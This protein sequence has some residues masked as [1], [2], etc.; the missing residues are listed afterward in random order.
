MAPNNIMQR[1][2]RLENRHTGEK[3]HI[4]RVR[5]KDGG[6]ILLLDGSLP[7]GS[8]GP[9]MH[10]HLTQLEEGTI[11]SGT[12]GAEVGGKRIRLEAG[13]GGVFPA[14]VAHTWWNDG[15]TLLEF[16]G[17]V[18]PAADL[19]RFLQAVFAVVNAGPKDR[20]PLFYLAHVLWRHRETQFI[21]APPRLVQSVMFPLVIAIGRLLGKY[22]GD[23]WPGSPASCPGAPLD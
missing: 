12:L 13:E 18:A 1:G 23:N 16:G 11:K 20:P 7:V 3:L 10:I 6:E 5:A 17:H 14:G 22:T 8:K 2:L 15:D 19:D 21:V 4:R 9:P